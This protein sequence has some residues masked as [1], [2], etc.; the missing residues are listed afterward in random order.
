[1]TARRINRAG[2]KPDRVARRARVTTRGDSVAAIA[3]ATG[4]LALAAAAALLLTSPSVAASRDGELHEETRQAINGF[5]LETGFVDGRR[6][7]GRRIAGVTAALGRPDYRRSA[8]ARYVV[9]YRAHPPFFVEVHFVRRQGVFRARAIILQDVTLEEARLGR[10]LRLLPPQIERR[11]L[12][13]YPDELE[14]V[15]P[16]QCRARGLCTGEFRAVGSVRRV[17]FGRVPSTGAR[18]IN[19]WQP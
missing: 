17:T 13:A 3:T 19:I 4:T 15:R 7:L 6:V 12:A 9:G 16:Y 18:F 11:I 5:D 8:G 10:V 1:M 14:L 2:A